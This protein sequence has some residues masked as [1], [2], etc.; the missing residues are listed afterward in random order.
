MAEGARWLPGGASSDYRLG[1]TALV[2]D[3]ADGALLWDVDGNRLIDYYC[4]AGPI[5]LGHNPAPVVEAVTRQVA[6]GVQIGAESAQEYDAARL[7]TELV[8]SAEMVR[9]ANTGSEAVQLA[10]R[11]ARGATGRDVVV[12]FEG[13]Y[14]GWLDSVFVGLPNR[15]SAAEAGVRR[16][17]TSS[18]G[19]DPAA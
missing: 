10:L 12:K 6:R 16:D 14:H 13:H 17:R 1:P 2:I 11:I 3:R 4:G 9:F 19:Q 7:V 5:I 18:A 8:P 15:P